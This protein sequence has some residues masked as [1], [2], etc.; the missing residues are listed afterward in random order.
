[1]P[2]GTT[3]SASW[4]LMAWRLVGTKASETIMTRQHLFS[5]PSFMPEEFDAKYDITFT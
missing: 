2:R 4:L 3:E 1:M 5:R